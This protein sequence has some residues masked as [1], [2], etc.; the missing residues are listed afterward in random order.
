[1][2]KTHDLHSHILLID[3]EES[4][5]DTYMEYLA[6]ESFQIEVSNCP[7]E[8]WKLI[9]KKKFDLIITDIKMPRLDG[10]EL[11]KIIKS[12]SKNK[13]VP[14]LIA[15]GSSSKLYESMARTESTIFHLEKPFSQNEFLAMIL[16]A[17]K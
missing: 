3:D 13:N 12:N 1:M 6:E 4:I 14:I 9:D 10:E 15:S 17:L 2:N 8:A 16:K 11:L 5:T 7:Q